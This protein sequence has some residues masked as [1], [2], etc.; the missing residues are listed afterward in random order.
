MTQNTKNLA[1]YIWKY[2][3]F[4]CNYQCDYIAL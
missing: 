2:F 1:A 4:G 3:A